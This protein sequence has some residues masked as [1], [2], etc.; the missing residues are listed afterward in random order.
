[1][2][3]LA[4]APGLR[5]TAV[6]GLWESAYVGPGEQEPYVNACVEVETC[7]APPALLEQTARLE[8]DFAR[9][10]HGA[11]RMVRVRHQQ[12][13]IAG[14]PAQSRY[15][16]GLIGATAMVS[17]KKMPGDWSTSRFMAAA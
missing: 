17:K 5:V 2:R 14:Y 13:P 16:F 6:S 3:D 10:L 11:K 1:M 8:T 15:E 4:A 7:L 12:H 9:D